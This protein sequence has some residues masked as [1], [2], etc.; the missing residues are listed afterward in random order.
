MK[1]ETNDTSIDLC[2]VINNRITDKEIQNHLNITAQIAWKRYGAK[3][4]TN[5]L[6]ETEFARR[7]KRGLAPVASIMK[8]GQVV[9]GKTLQELT[10]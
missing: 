7:A 3:L 8:E 6:T 5:V 1:R 9:F 10:K 4:Q 2:V